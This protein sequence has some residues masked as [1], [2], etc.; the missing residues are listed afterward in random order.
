MNMPVDMIVTPQ[1]S[2]YQNLKLQNNIWLQGQVQRYMQDYQRNMG[3]NGVA[4]PSILLQLSDIV[5]VGTQFNTL[6]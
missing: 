1:V 2:Q 4:D 5:N 6:A 3:L